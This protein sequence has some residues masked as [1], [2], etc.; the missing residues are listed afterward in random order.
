LATPACARLGLAAPS[1]LE[2]PLPNAS[3]IPAALD[4]IVKQLGPYGWLFGPP[5]VQ[6]R[7]E[8]QV[9]LR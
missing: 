1:L 4:P 7:M 5:A 2:Q 6:A 8:Y 3:V 9:D